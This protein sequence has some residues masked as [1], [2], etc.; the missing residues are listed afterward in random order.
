MKP[1]K[2]LALGIAIS[3]VSLSLSAAQPPNSNIEYIRPSELSGSSGSNV[4]GSAHGHVRQRLAYGKGFRYGHSVN[5]AMG[6]IIIWSASPNRLHGVSTRR[7]NVHR[8]PRNPNGLRLV[9][10]PQYGKTSKPG[11]GR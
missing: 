6:S 4:P 7:P 2:S 10:K 11:Y 5:G 8:G 3:A 9:Y 1:N